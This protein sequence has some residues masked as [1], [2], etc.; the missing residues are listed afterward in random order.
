[1]ATQ[2]SSAN[3][4]VEIAVYVHLVNKL[5]IKCSNMLRVLKPWRGSLDGP[6]GDG[7]KNS[8]IKRRKTY[9]SN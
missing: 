9:G 5:D 2:K 1:M 7:S 3:F 8:V 4:A 6:L